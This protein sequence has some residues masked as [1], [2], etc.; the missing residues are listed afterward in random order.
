MSR[1]TI[2]FLAF[3]VACGDA[4]SSSPCQVAL[5]ARISCM[6]Q[7]GVPVDSQQ[8]EQAKTACVALVLTKPGFGGWLDCQTA[9]FDGADCPSPEA[10]A[11]AENEA[12]AC[13]NPLED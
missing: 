4:A 6:E 12:N 7:A 5:D 1:F 11:L 2:F 10:V 13:G 3:S 9:A 8:L